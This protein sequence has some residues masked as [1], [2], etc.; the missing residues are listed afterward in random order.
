MRQPDALTELSGHQKRFGPTAEAAPYREVL[1]M[2]DSPV[3]SL[4]HCLRSPRGSRG[5][6]VVEI[7]K[8]E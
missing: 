5:Y 2:L 3:T 4:L 7:E 8:A 1:V 6:G